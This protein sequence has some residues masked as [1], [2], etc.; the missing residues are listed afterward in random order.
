MVMHLFIWFVS[1]SFVQFAFK[2]AFRC[3]WQSLYD[4][5]TP[6]FDAMGKKAFYLGEVGH[7]ARMKLV[8]NMIMGR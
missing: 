3:Q 8:V 1:R 4:E 2:R 7:G 6:A 5:V